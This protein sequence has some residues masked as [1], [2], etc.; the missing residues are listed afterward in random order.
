MLGIDSIATALASNHL[1]TA[2]H[3]LA[4]AGGVVAALAAKAGKSYGVREHVEFVAQ[5]LQGMT[6]AQLGKVRCDLL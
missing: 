2:D 1:V 6:G 4:T 5:L 3:I